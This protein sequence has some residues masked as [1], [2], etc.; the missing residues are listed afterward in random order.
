MTSALSSDE[1][2]LGQAFIM[3]I[4]LG[5]SDDSKMP[6]GTV[7]LACNHQHWLGDFWEECNQHREMV[8][9]EGTLV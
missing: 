1:P 3:H 8:G 2:E 4:S 7:V 6:A 5:I 9:P